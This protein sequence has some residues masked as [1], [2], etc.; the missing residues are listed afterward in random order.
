MLGVGGGQIYGAVVI[1]I[2]FEG[3]RGAGKS[4]VMGLLR[5][6]LVKAGYQSVSENHLNH[7]MDVVF[8]LHTER[9]VT[10]GVPQL[11]DL[12]KKLNA[13]ESHGLL[14]KEQARSVACPEC[15]AKPGLKC[16]G[17]RGRDRSS[18]HIDR[19]KRYRT[20]DQTTNGAASGTL[21]DMSGSPG[22]IG[23]GN[24]KRPAPGQKDT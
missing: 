24:T 4:H 19:W 21:G 2:R 20:G 10:G 6:V 8:T 23:R 9:A 7:T 13:R 18:C 11:E 22:A 3:P 17:A 5:D 16:T 12:V 14:Y 1:R 15:G